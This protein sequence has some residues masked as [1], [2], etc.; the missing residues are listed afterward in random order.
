[1]SGIPIVGADV[2]GYTGHP[3]PE[4]FARWMQLGSLIPLFRGHSEQGT[5]DQE[6]W[7]FGQQVEDISRDY[8]ELRYS[9]IQMMYDLTYESYIT[10]LPINRP[11]FMSYPNDKDTHGI[12]DQFM[13]GDDLMVAPVVEEGTTSRQVYFPAGSRWIDYWTGDIYNGGQYS[14]VQAPLETMPLYIRE[15]GII[16]TQDP[17]Q[18]IGERQENP[19]TIH[20]YPTL[21]V[22]QSSEYQLYQDDENTMDYQADGYRLTKITQSTVGSDINIDLAVLHNQFTPS[23]NYQILTVHGV[24]TVSQVNI[25]SSELTAENSCQLS[26]SENSFCVDADNKKL[27]F[28]IFDLSE[29]KS[30][31]ISL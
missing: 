26:S 12:E 19:M 1:L 27:I 17:V 8:L 9:L 15:G 4:L 23:E 3:T 16:I 20:F 25:N 18:Y 7:V 29:N 31:K 21:D 10:G 2:G 14:A 11:L 30:L 5:P 24:D 6:P 13:F 22:E 28:K